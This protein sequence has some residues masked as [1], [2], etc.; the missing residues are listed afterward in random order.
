M[1]AKELG[2]EPS[3]RDEVGLESAL[4]RPFAG[5]GEQEVHGSAW[6][7]G[8]ALAQAFLIHHPLMDGNKRCALILMQL[9]W[10]RMGLRWD[11]GDAPSVA[12]F[13]KTYL[14]LDMAMGKEVVAEMADALV[15]DEPLEDV[16]WVRRQIEIDRQPLHALGLYGFGV[17]DE[18]QDP[19]E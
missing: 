18:P 5:F 8:I 17:D 12:G 2:Q 9:L 4:A 6:A 19:A 7:K 13:I 14:I 16:E 15:P 1:V 3:V 11:L 10:H